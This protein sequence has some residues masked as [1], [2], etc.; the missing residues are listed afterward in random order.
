MTARVILLGPPGSG[1]GTQARG[2][3]D[4]LGVPAI[5]TGAIFRDHLARDTELGRLARVH[6]DAGHLVPDDVTNG[7]VAARLGEPDA[8]VGFVLDGYPRNLAQVA[9]LDAFLAG[10]GVGVEAALFL[11]IPD[12]VIVARLL[13][14]AEIEGRSDDTEPIIRERIGIYH[15]KTEPIVGAYDGRGLLASVDGVGEIGEVAARLLAAV[16][17]RPS[18]P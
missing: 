12:A 9:A 16:P 5:S 2:L 13:R 11:R 15:A 4:E 14:R 8:A 18:R 17:R 6:I 1:K 3:A 7:L 10:Y